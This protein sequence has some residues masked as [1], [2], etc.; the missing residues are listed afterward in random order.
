MPFPHR[1]SS[2]KKILKPILNLVAS[3][4]LASG[5]SLTTWAQSEPVTVLDPLTVTASKPRIGAQ[6]AFDEYINIELKNFQDE[7]LGRITDL[8]IDL[9]NG[10]IVVVL[11]ECDKSLGVEGKVVS[12]PPLALVPDL[13]NRTYRLNASPETFKSAAAV[14][15]ATWETAGRSQRVAAAYQL[16]GQEP[17]FLQ[18]GDT[19]SKTDARPLVPLGYVERA[20]KIVDVPVG[21][22]EG[23]ELGKVWS[24]TMDITQGRILSVIVLAPGNFKTKSV[25]PAMALSWNEKR[26]ALVIDDSKLEFA[27]EPRYIFTDASFG[28]EAYSHE[29]S[30]KGPKNSY[31]RVQGYSYRDVDQTM[32]INTNIRKSKINA[33][34]V[35]VGTLN[36][37]I[38][39]RGWVDTADDKRRVG[40]I[41]IA[42]SRVELVDNQLKVGKPVTINQAQPPHS[43]ASTPV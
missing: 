32:N 23:Q 2:Q 26:D 42:A 14:D 8:G 3:A 35:E 6:V 15:L 29:E 41:A 34:N 37:R 43:R 30:Y 11:V 10:R 9:I 19:A 31:T 12:V 22:R 17:Y 1:P 5:V 38:T 18:E 36:D 25:V 33:R 7:S 16:F 21:N 13:I 28:Q 4:I 39:L 20:S 27:K 40:E 24:L